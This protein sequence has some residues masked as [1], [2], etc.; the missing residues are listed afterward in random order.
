MWISFIS[1]STHISRCLCSIRSHSHRA[2]LVSASPVQFHDRICIFLLIVVSESTSFPSIVRLS[3][4][5]LF[6]FRCSSL[7]LCQFIIHSICLTRIGK[8]VFISSFRSHVRLCDGNFIGEIDLVY[9]FGVF[10]ARARAFSW[11]NTRMKWHEESNNSE[12]KKNCVFLIWLFLFSV[13]I[14]IPMFD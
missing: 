4:G 8:N 7:A 2:V 13:R 14:L 10:Q 12:R 1:K 5:R 3:F 9:F 6:D 11:A